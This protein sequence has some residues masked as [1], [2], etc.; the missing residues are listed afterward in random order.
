ML[1]PVSPIFHGRHIFA[2]AAAY[3]AKGVAIE[4]FGPALVFSTLV[5]APYKEASIKIG[6]S[7]V[8]RR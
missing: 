4:A 5:P 2:P 6:D 7:V 1:Q 8:I 3:L